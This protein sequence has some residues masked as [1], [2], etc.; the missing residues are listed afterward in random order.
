M[1]GSTLST[2]VLDVT[3]GAPAAGATVEL[4]RDDQLVGTDATDEDGRIAKLGAELAPGRY[5]LVFD[6][7]SYF[8]DRAPFLVRVTLDVDLP[9]GHSHVPLLV[10]PFSCVSYRGR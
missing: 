1:T 2:H 3:T 9:V 10:S 4:Y 7:A 6:T 8:T 5:R